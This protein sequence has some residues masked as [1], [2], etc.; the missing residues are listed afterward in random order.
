MNVGVEVSQ[1]KKKKEKGG[2]KKRG[3]IPLATQKIKQE[4]AKKHQR[5]YPVTLSEARFW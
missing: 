4:Q 5:I 1:E 2:V 3:E